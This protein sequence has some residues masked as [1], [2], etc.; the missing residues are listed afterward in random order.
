M[1][2]NGLLYKSSYTT[3]TLPSALSTAP[4]P[5]SIHPP[6]FVVCN[7]VH[8]P[9]NYCRGRMCHSH[10]YFVHTSEI[11]IKMEANSCFILHYRSK[12]LRPV[13]FKRVQQFKRQN[14]RRAIISRFTV[15]LEHINV[16]TSLWQYISIIYKYMS[17]DMAY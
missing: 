8:V 6:P 15:I 5:P 3:I 1:V 17:K 10:L 2:H 11:K 14:K 9:S 12:L 13:N 7:G 16:L 4:S